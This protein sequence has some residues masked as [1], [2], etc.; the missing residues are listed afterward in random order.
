MD[1]VIITELTVLVHLERRFVEGVD[2]KIAISMCN[3]QIN[4]MW[5]IIT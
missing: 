5:F 2:L 3:V 1:D 4:E